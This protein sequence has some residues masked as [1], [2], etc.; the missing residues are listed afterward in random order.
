MS[1]AKR[2][3]ARRRISS[4][5]QPG[6][7]ARPWPVRRRLAGLIAV[8]AGLW[9]LPLGIVTGVA[10]SS[11]GGSVTIYPGIESPAAIAAGPDGAL[12]FTNTFNGSIGRVT[13]SGKITIYNAGIV[14]PEG[15][16]AGPDGALWFTD[17]NNSIGRI[18]SSVT[19]GSAAY[20]RLGRYQKNGEGTEVRPPGRLMRDIRGTSA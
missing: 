10:R 14:Q 18:T 11:G 17:T 7:A 15:I 3:L 16:T 1:T 6:L 9:V 19:R 8:L 2:G 20:L 4:A 5:R 12:W 13:T